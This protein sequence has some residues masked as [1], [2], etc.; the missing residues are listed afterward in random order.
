[1]TL[2]RTKKHIA[3]LKDEHG[4]TI[5]M[6]LLALLVAAMVSAVILSAAMSAVKQE[7]SDTEFQQCQLD[8]QS[9]AQ[10]VLADIVGDDN[11]NGR[12]TVN[13]KARK[14]VDEGG[15]E[16]W[17]YDK[18]VAGGQESYFGDELVEAVTA[19]HYG[20]AGS[21]AGV[22]SK[23]L[24]DVKFSKK[25]ATTSGTSGSVDR[26]V[27]MTLTAQQDVDK[28]GVKLGTYSYVFAFESHDGGIQGGQTLYMALNEKCPPPPDGD[29]KTYTYSWSLKRFYTAEG[30]K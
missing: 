29:E 25:A 27:R 13:V 1:M 21:N 20:G 14:Q 8:L 11:E 3:S 18:P 30:D 17:T 6:A 15:Q 28:D 4:V 19:L 5:L 2:T 16:T 12:F 23:N 22:Y 10:F 24:S 9:A 26:T 7:K